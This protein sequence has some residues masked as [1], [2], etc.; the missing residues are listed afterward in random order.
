MFQ[1]QG[2]F[3]LVD[4]LGIVPV[5]HVGGVP[6]G[7]LLGEP[8]DQR[9]IVPRAE[10]V[11]TCF[12]IIVFAAVAEGVRIGFNRGSLVAEGIVIVVLAQFA[13]GIG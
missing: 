1:A 7:V 12:G 5:D 11:Q 3:P 10:V 13:V 2:V 9:V 8:A 4:L 6:V